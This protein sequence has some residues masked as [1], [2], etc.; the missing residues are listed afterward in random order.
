MLLSWEVEVVMGAV[1][2]I[3]ARDAS[4]FASFLSGIALFFRG[5]REAL[6]EVFFGNIIRKSLRKSLNMSDFARAM[7]TKN[8]KN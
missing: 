1:L 2:P 7:L 4:F 8:P 5:I 3:L 6:G